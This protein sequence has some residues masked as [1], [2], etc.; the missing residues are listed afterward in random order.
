VTERGSAQK[1]IDEVRR[2]WNAC[3]LFVGEGSHAPGSREWFEEHERIYLRDCFAGEAPAIFTAGLAAGARILD[4]GCGPGF[5]V[6]FFARRG[7]ASVHACDLTDAAV[8]LTTRS[9]SIFGLA[10]DVQVGNA[11]QLPY[12]DAAVDHVNCQGVIH[13][14]PNPRKALEECARV[15]APGGTICFSVYHR[16]LLLRHPAALRAFTR[17]F[18][19]VVGL[20]GRGRES[21]LS[22][23]D[24]DEI[25]RMYDGHENPIGRAYTR[26]ELQQMVGG[27]FTIEDVEFFYFP[28]RAL[29][30]SIP[31]PVHRWLSRRAGLLI[32]LRG[33]KVAP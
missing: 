13:H 20:R 28:A 21:L 19:G 4:V 3:P 11:E 17:L 1:T 29:P 33:R 6:R 31:R 16:N 10:A 32:I 24:A 23:G 8:D 26:A 12:A 25:V 14:T 7:F 15:L 30:F 9:L 5:W 18:G 27:L 2:F 22:A